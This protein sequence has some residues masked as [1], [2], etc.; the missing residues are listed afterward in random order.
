MMTASAAKVVPLRVRYAD[1]RDEL[2]AHCAEALALVD[3][4]WP[5]VSAL[6]RMAIELGP[7][8][9]R[10]TIALGR[11]LARYEARHRAPDDPAAE[12]VA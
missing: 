8:A 3:E 5:H 6:E 9:L 4:A 7:L 1:T 11:L 2:T 12:A 10:H